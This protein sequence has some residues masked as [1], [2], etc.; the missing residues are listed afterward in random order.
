MTRQG[1]SLQLHWIFQQN[2]GWRRGWG[3][4]GVPAFTFESFHQNKLDSKLG[5]RRGA[6]PQLLF[7]SPKKGG[8]KACDRTGCQPS[9][10]IRFNIIS[11]IHSL[12]QDGVPAFYFIGFSNKIQVGGE[13][14]DRTCLLYTSP[15]PRDKRQSR[16]PSSA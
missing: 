3:Q 8:F 14:W 16:M 7:V 9:T 10:C 15:S 5:T 2:S 13:A 4:D 12:G 1:A 11:W 6:S